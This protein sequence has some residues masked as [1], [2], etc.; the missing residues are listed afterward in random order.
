MAYLS[1]R[2]DGEGGD[3]AGCVGAGGRGAGRHGV[4]GGRLRGPRHQ[5]RPRHRSAELRAHP[6]QPQ[7]RAV[8]SEHLLK[9]GLSSKILHKQAIAPGNP[10]V[11]GPGLSTP[12]HCSSNLKRVYCDVYSFRNTNTSGQTVCCLSSNYIAQSIENFPPLFPS[13]DQSPL[14]AAPSLP[15]PSVVRGN[16]SQDRI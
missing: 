4:Q 9:L 14:N 13:D 5:P 3:D 1:G 6:G 16:C 2:E 15:C 7:G 8:S 12:T 10:S 11:C